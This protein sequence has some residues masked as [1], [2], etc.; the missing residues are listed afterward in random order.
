VAAAVSD[1]VVRAA[2]AV[3]WRAA[4]GSTAVEVALVHRPRYDDWSL[5]KGKLDAGEHPLVAACREV[6]EETAVQPVI[7]PRLPTVSYQ[8]PGGDG[9]VLKIVDYWAM[10]A[11]SGDQGFTPNQEVDALRWLPPAEARELLTYQH[12]RPVLDAFAA[13]P[14]VTGTILLI[15]HARAGSRKKWSGD[16]DLRPLDRRGRLQATQLAMALPCFR[17]TRILAADRVR[18][19]QT[20]QPL[21]DELGLSV[22]VEHVFSEHAADP[23]Q[24]AARLRDLAEQGGV[25]AVCSQGG[26]IPEALARL[27]EADG[28]AL[29][30]IESKKG[31]VWVLSFRDSTLIAADY[32]PDLEP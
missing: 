17:P 14:P 22:E 26:M 7:G 15:R 27:A 28:L 31:S 5:P 11:I 8:V 30:G 23:E 19:V 3:L 24:T 16:D 13:L 1:P 9:P 4:D 32:L 21:A 12:D 29:H 20:V 6:V 18:C 2:G 25:S 10:R